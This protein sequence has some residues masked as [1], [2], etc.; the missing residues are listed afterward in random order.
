MEEYKM[1]WTK[2]FL[3]VTL[4]SLSL[5]T[6]ACGNGVASGTDLSSYPESVQDGIVSVE[7]YNYAKNFHINVLTPVNSMID[8]INLQ[9]E[10][11]EVA[12]DKEYRTH[13][14]SALNILDNTLSEFDDTPKLKTEADKEIDFQLQKIIHFQQELNE[15]QREY[16][17]T[18]NEELEMK[19]LISSGL[20]KSMVKDFDNIFSKHDQN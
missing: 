12:L 11:T 2:N 4:L 16:L 10:N 1:K 5:L 17:L 9:G 18:R 14:S 13:F 15:L 3:L 20:L 6:S 8:M 19:L 7:Y